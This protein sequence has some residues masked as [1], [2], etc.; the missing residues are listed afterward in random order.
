MCKILQQKEFLL[1]ALKS[2]ETSIT[3]IDQGENTALTDLRNKPTV[4]AFSKD[5]K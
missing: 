5:K 3:S 2:V 4:N 1:Q